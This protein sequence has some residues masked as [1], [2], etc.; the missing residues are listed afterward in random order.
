MPSPVPPPTHGLCADNPATQ[1]QV[2]TSPGRGV[3]SSCR[4]LNGI[5]EQME[6]FSSSLNVLASRVEAS[7]L[8]MAQERELG[9]RQ[10]DKQL[11]GTPYLPS[12]IARPPRW[13]GGQN[14][15]AP[16]PVL[17]ER[18]GQQQ[19]DMEEERGRLQEVIGKMEAHLSEQ[20]RLLEQ[21]CC[22]SLR[23][24]PCCSVPLLPGLS[25]AQAGCL[26]PAPR[27]PATWPLSIVF[28]PSA[29]PPFPPSICDM[30]TDT[31]LNV[32]LPP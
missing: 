31:P 1:A 20:S 26:P 5:I 27:S 18:L 8:T 9:V 23:S 11:R 12:P 29:A 17:Q 25:T 24:V 3:P 6:K 30:G 7:H 32:T 10:Q 16:S 21:V 14:V 15:Y 28:P 22:L 19:R 13:K 4:S 2:W